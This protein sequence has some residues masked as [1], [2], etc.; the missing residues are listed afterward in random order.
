M[1]NFDADSVFSRQAERTVFARRCGDMVSKPVLDGAH[2][3]VQC[4]DVQLGGL[5][6]VRDVVYV[7]THA[8]WRAR[9]RE[10]GIL[11]ADCKKIEQLGVIAINIRADFDHEQALFC[12]LRVDVA[13]DQVGG[14]FGRKPAQQRNRRSPVALLLVQ[15]PQLFVQKI[16]NQA[17]IQCAHGSAGKITALNVA[18][19]P[20]SGGQPNLGIPR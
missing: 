17:G 9:Q 15:A 16:L 14:F 13:F 1:H 19:R 3:I 20:K 10:R 11:A 4:G 5:G 6:G 7:A 8:L 12:F 18:N 2:I